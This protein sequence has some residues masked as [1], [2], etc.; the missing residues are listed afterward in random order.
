MRTLISLLLLLPAAAFAVKDTYAISALLQDRASA[1]LALM[2]R[3]LSSAQAD[4][5]KADVD[6]QKARD[7]LDG[8]M[9]L[10]VKQA[11]GSPDLIKAIKEFYVAAQAYFDAPASASLADRSNTARLKSDLSAKENALRMEMKLAGIGG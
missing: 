7:K 3:N 4:V 5:T 11:K 10:A 9:Q 8:D 6:V 1:D 2:T